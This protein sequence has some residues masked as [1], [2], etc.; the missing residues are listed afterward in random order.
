[1]SELRRTPLHEAHLRLGA[2]MVD[3]AGFS[4]PVQYDSIV[5]EHRA[6]REAAGL[7]DVSHMGQLHLEGPSALASADRLLSRRVSNQREGRVRYALLCNEAGG[8]VD[9]V[10]AY[11]TGE[12]ALFLCVNAANVAK[13]HS[14]V[15]KHVED[16]TRVHDASDDTGLLALQGP[17]SGD[18]LARVGA[19]DARQ[20][21]RYA[22]ASFELAG[23]RALISRTG[24]TGSDGYELYL[25]AAG[26]E[27]VFEALLAEGQRDGL[28]P[29]GLGARDTL[30]LE[31]A[32]P[33]YGHEL[34]AESSPLEAGLDRFVELEHGGFIGAEAI[35]RRA[36]AGHGR[37]L[38]G[39]VLEDRGVARAG[40]EIAVDGTRVGRVTSG[41]PSPTLGR[42]IGL[43]WV[44]PHLAAPG[45][46]FDVVIRGRAT[47]AQAV[48]TPF[49]EIAG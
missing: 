39:F 29:A 26:S 3:F 18:I 11:R 46:R 25:E 37:A 45:S 8:V 7:F 2:R 31:A 44:P 12:S 40:Y 36:A 27:R 1:M 42:S 34:D 32:M 20:L 30:R 15:L 10:T 47:A 4:M 41:A 21:K 48:E 17:A 22:F 43:A 49:V 33:L 13:D 23:A 35:A 28:V 6:V 16:G 19:G 14:W 9:D 38:V 5:A 24:Y